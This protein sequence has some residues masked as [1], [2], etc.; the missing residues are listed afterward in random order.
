VKTPTLKVKI[1]LILLILTGGAMADTRSKY[2]G[3]QYGQV[4]VPVVKAKEKEVKNNFFEVWRPHNNAEGH[5]K[6][7][8]NSVRKKRGQ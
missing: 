3:K 8:F 2:L 7:L 1:L 6:N 4:K 5:L